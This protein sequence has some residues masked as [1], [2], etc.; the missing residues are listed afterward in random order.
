MLPASI[1]IGAG[2]LWYG[3]SAQ[4]RLFWIM[5]DIRNAIFMAGAV[6]CNISVNA[7]VVDTYRQYAAS[8]LAAVTTLRS[9]ASFS[10]PLFAPYMYAR[11]DY[12]WTMLLARPIGMGNRPACRGLALEVWREAPEEKPTCS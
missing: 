6:T 9:L 3:W 7:Y 8:A 5:P 11:L 2:L 10:F 4:Q 12:G 1:A